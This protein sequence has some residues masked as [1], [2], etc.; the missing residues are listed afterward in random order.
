[1]NAPGE[2]ADMDEVKTRLDALEGVVL[3]LMRTEQESDPLTGAMNLSGL[4]MLADGAAA[5]ELAE[6]YRRLHARAVAAKIG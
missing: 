6:A 4:K 3:L 2:N 1:M 5:P